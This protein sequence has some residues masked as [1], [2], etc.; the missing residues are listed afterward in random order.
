[1][2]DI[3]IDMLSLFSRVQV[4]KPTALEMP[5]MINRARIASMHAV[6]RHVWNIVT[7]DFQGQFIAQ[8]T[9]FLDSLFFSEK[10][11]WVP[12]PDITTVRELYL[13]S[14]Q[15]KDF[16][17]LHGFLS[18][19]TVASSM[20]TASYDGF[21]KIFKDIFEN[22]LGGLLVPIG[23]EVG[24]GPA[25][26]GADINFFIDPIGLSSMKYPMAYQLA[27][28]AFSSGPLDF[29]FAEGYIALNSPVRPFYG[30]VTSITWSP[31]LAST[32]ATQVSS[33]VLATG[34]SFKDPMSAMTNTWSIFTQALIEG[35]NTAVVEPTASLSQI[36]GSPT[37]PTSSPVPLTGTINWSPL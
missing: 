31:N 14:P 36:Y 37:C 22:W 16:S 7:Q 24:S 3:T 25:P 8:P 27:S 29:P 26:F 13:P 34:P 10:G 4:E 19:P 33:Q 5:S 15:F 32:L 20:A 23:A 17:V 35:L 9:S 6:A 2:T 28:E 12:I 21:L 1:M 11:S 30:Q 18:V